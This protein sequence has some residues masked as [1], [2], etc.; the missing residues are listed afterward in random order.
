MKILIVDDETGVHDQL[1]SSVPWSTLGWDIVGDAYDGEQACSLA[2]ELQPDIILTDIKMPLMDGLSFMAWLREV[3]FAGKVIVLSG[4][5]DFEYSRTAFL[6]DVFDYLLKPV[7]EAELLGVL[8]KA[9][10]QIQHESKTKINQIDQRAVSN[11]GFVLMQDEFLTNIVSGTIRDE[12]EMFV[13]VDP[14]SVSLPESKFTVIVVQLV[15]SEVK[16]QQTYGG[17][18]PVFYFAVRNILQEWLAMESGV[19]FRNLTKTHEFIILYPDESKNAEKS[20]WLV[21]RIH[22]G[23]SSFLRV[24]ARFGMSS[25]KQR[26]KAIPDAYLEAHQTIEGLQINSGHYCAQYVSGKVQST[27]VHTEKPPQW[28]HLHR[29]LESLL[30]TG[31][32]PPNVNLL[33]NLDEA[34]SEPVIGQMSGVEMR[35]TVSLFVD[36]IEKGFRKP[37]EPLLVSIHQVKMNLNDWNLQQAWALLKAII[38]YVQEESNGDKTLKSGKQIIEIV[39]KYVVDHYQSVSL[40]EISQRFYLNKNYFCSLFKSV[41]GE[42]FTEFLTYVRMEQAKWQLIHTDKKMYE[43][44]NFVGYEDQRYFSKVFKKYSG[45]QPSEFRS[46]SQ[47][48]G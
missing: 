20:H 37:I 15:D 38:S 19:V 39:K 32:L 21:Q 11:K 25:V 42:N 33:E 3:N 8:S 40:E 17:N 4:Y 35:K 2:Q 26:P 12:N 45:V 29:L 13:G 23:L 46:N 6:L 16:V 18:R 28:Q 34:L 47:L 44:A 41:T 7:N 48:G 36:C 24:N 31:T 14:L 27:A 10:E 9:A 43:I 22:S 30:E 1:R 5:G